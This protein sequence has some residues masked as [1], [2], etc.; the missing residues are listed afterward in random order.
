MMMHYIHTQTYNLVLIFY[1]FM[2]VVPME[3]GSLAASL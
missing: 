2:S 1:Y 3:T